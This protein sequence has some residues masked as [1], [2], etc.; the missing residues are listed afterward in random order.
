MWIRASLAGFTFARHPKPLGWYRCRADSLSSDDTR[1]LSGILR[2]FAK[3]RPSLPVNSAER[4]ILDRQVARFEMELVAA[5][6]R[7]SLMRGD[8]AQAGRELAVLSA[9]R[10]GWLLAAAARAVAVAPRA[11]LAA[12]RVRQRL[13]GLA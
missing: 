13:R 9:R 12:F 8:A 10:G 5:N 3:T 2:V 7:R 11:A 4:A 6:A 1:M